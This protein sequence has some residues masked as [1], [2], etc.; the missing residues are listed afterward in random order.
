MNVRGCLY[1]KLSGNFD[2]GTWKKT[3]QIVVYVPT[4]SAAVSAPQEAGV[5]LNAFVVGVLERAK[6]ENTHTHKTSSI[7]AFF[8]VRLAIRITGCFFSPRTVRGG[9]EG[10]E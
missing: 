6:R 9:G 3:Y 5:I 7:I 4:P 2:M 1:L 8:P 10:G